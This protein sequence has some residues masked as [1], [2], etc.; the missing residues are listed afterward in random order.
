[1][2]S[3]ILKEDKNEIEVSMDNATVAEILRVYLNE[4]GVDFAAWRKEHPTKPA[5]MKV[6][7]SGR[8]AKKEISDAISSIK[9]DLNKISSSIKK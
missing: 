2:E 1:M 5:I 9:K 3:E 7:S 8:T 6:Q 4:Q